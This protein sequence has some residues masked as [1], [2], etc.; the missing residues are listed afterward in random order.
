VISCGGRKPPYWLSDQAG[1]DASFDSH[2]PWDATINGNQNVVP[3]QEQDIPVGDEGVVGAGDASIMA[4]A[5]PGRKRR[6]AYNELPRRSD[7]DGPEF[8]TARI[9]RMRVRTKLK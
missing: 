3:R 9:D 2:Q 5:A 4:V 7:G 8:G 6:K 1:D